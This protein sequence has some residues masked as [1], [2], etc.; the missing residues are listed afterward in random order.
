MKSDFKSIK[1]DASRGAILDAAEACVAKGKPLHIANV[2]EEAGIA[3]GTVYRY[4]QDKQT[5]GDELIGRMLVALVEH[6]ERAH[7]PRGD[8]AG[9]LEAFLR[10]ICEAALDHPGALHL[11]LERA[12]WSQLGTDHDVGGEAKA[13]YE[14]YCRLERKI[15]RLVKL[16]K[17]SGTTASLFLRA[18]VMAGLTHLAGIDEA[19]RRK[20]V[21]DL[22]RLATQGLLGC[23][24]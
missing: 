19:G 17:I 23:A 24:T 2:A 13:A 9:V 16:K 3:V 22:I 11:F 6:I 4:F 8:A 12:T 7:D 18:S 15:L 5:L 20:G 10:A 14:R 1:Q 21:E